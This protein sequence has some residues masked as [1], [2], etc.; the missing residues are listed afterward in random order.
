MENMTLQNIVR[1]CGGIYQGTET[2]RNREITG[3]ALDCRKVEKGFCYIAIQG[4]PCGGDAFISKK[5]KKEATLFYFH[6]PLSDWE[7]QSTRGN[8][9]NRRENRNHPESRLLLN[10]VFTREK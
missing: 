1:A 6:R 8:N 9:N 5:Q 10:P 7:G 4:M 2:D 3:V